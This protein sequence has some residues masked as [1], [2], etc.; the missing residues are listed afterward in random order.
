MQDSAG[1][2]KVHD[3]CLATFDT[4]QTCA[5]DSPFCEQQL[6]QCEAWQV[7]MPQSWSK[8][9]SYLQLQAGA[10]AAYATRHSTAMS[11]SDL[12]HWG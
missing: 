7:I 11:S 3:T 8:E 2:R 10:S 5:D 12:K 6:L 4:F 1:F 9:L